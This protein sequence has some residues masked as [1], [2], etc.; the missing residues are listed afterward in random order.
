MF[1][2]KKFCLL[3]ALL[4][5]VFF[6]SACSKFIA[7]EK[8]ND[9]TEIPQKTN[10]VITEN[11]EKK[12]LTREEVIAIE[13]AFNERIFQLEKV[14]DS[15]EILNFKSKEEL[16]DYVKEVAGEELATLFIEN[17][18][19]EI[20][21]KLYVIP[22][23]TPPRLIYDSPFEI[24]KIDDNTYEIVQDEEN[25]MYGPYRLLIEFKYI[26][27]KWKM[28]DRKAEGRE[29]A[30]QDDSN[31]SKE[32]RIDSETAKAIISDTA[33][34]LIYALSIKDV[35]T[36]AEYVHPEKGVRFTP[37]TFVSLEEDLV[38]SQEEIKNFFEDK[39]I[40]T[41]GYYDGSGEKI[42]LTPAEYYDSF[43]YSADFIN[44]PEIGYNEVLSQGN[45]LENQFEVYHNPIIVEY[46]FPGFNPEYEG[47][48][49][50]SLRLVFE[51]YEGTWKLSGIIHNQWTI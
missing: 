40:Y 28:T 34:R 9:K 23:G 42:N 15:N 22:K 14:E 51:E 17:F 46:Y 30:N 11:K 16:M 38:F 27:G 35:N 12:K 13:K 19:E 47:L 39:N 2:Y 6:F 3:P 26:D 48:D 44:A 21:G 4:I 32:E 5:F 33:N 25:E 49:W 7:G 1:K 18:Y 10:E 37:Y 45:M 41:W 8:Q 29:N 43:V 36:I 31:F 20:D 50:Q 24:N